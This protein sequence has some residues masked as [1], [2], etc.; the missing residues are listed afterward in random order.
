VTAATIS[1][2]VGTALSY[3][4]TVKA[5]NAVSFTL[6]GAP[7]GMSINTAGVIAWASP[8]AG[9]YAV[10]VIAKDTKTGMSGQATFNFSVVASGLSIT[11]P[12]MTGTAGKAITGS[13][14]ISAPGATSVSISVTGA[15]LGLN[16][17][18][19]GLNISTSW[20]SP[21]KGNYTMAVVVTDNLGRKATANVP[22]TIN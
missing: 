19:S 7:A 12:A 18:M 16:F 13:I 17:S 3:T 2:T 14:S 9:N 11:A 4:V 8:V 1:G 21:V 10:T 5:S 6:T 22:I 20:A 15:P